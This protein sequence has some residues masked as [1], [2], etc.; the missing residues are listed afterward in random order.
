VN[1]KLEDWESGDLQ[2]VHLFQDWLG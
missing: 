1:F 2:H